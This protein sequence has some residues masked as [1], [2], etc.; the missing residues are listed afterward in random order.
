MSRQ[1]STNWSRREERNLEPFLW[2]YRRLSWKARSRVYY[3]KYRISRSGE[4]LRGKRNELRRRY[5]ID[6]LP[7]LSVASDAERRQAVMARRGKSSL[8][9]LAPLPVIVLRTPNIKV[10]HTLNMLR[11]LRASSNRPAKGIFNMR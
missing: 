6:H 9:T 11:Q 1:N 5:S 4:S 3:R 2:R 8:E 10:V 7:A